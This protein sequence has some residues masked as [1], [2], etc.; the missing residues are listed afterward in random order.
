MRITKTPGS[1][2]VG[3]SRRAVPSD[4]RSPRA[5]R[6]GY[7]R[8]RRRADRRT[9]EVQGAD[10]LRRQRGRIRPEPIRCPAALCGRVHVRE[11]SGT[12]RPHDRPLGRGASLGA[13]LRRD[14]HAVRVGRAVGRADDRENRPER[15]RRNRRAARRQCADRSG[16]APGKLAA[17]YRAGIS[18]L[19]RRS[20]RFLPE[21]E[22]SESSSR[23]RR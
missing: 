19:D 4:G 2:R 22:R 3:V 6:T 10:L 5:R 21:D 18:G 13:A 14:T 12:D 8:P 1:V 23:K 15:I 16:R 11:A 17:E 9:A 20:K 7:L